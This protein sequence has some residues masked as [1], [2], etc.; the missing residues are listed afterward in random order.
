MSIIQS[1]VPENW[2]VALVGLTH[3]VPSLVDHGIDTVKVFDDKDDIRSR[4]IKWRAARGEGDS[5]PKR[6][7]RSIMEN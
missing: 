6:R 5:V 3:M 2:T 1:S 7:T 4:L